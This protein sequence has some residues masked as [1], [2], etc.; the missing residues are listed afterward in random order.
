MT[1][2][3]WHV[4]RVPFICRVR[5]PQP[6]YAIK[7]C[8]HCR[9]QGVDCLLCLS[10]LLSTSCKGARVCVES[11]LLRAAS[12]VASSACTAHTCT[13]ISVKQ[14]SAVTPTA[15]TGSA[16]TDR[17]QAAKKPA[18]TCDD[19]LSDPSAGE[20]SRNSGSQLTFLLPALSLKRPQIVAYMQL[21]DP[22]S[23]SAKRFPSFRTKVYTS[24]RLRS[25]STQLK[26]GVLVTC[27][28]YLAPVTSACGDLFDS[29]SPYL[30]INM[31]WLSASTGDLRL[32]SL[33][34]CQRWRSIQQYAKCR[35]PGSK[36]RLLRR[37]CAAH[38]MAKAGT[39]LWSRRSPTRT[40]EPGQALSSH[41]AAEHPIE[42]VSQERPAESA[43]EQRKAFFEAMIRSNSDTFVTVGWHSSQ[44]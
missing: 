7:H 15:W 43:V 27:H 25:T 34:D 29:L 10:H 39:S 32:P 4:S 21:L 17:S 19:A 33:T 26:L 6:I 41:S 22:F 37:S 9:I 2:T 30:Q 31:Y 16:R 24:C 3:C 12:A 8:I 28:C 5:G 14:A 40:T 20:L 36:Q 18:D 38:S 23:V 44:D 1:I 13:V 11:L 42:M 35:H